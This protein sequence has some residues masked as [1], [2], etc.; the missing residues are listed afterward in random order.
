MDTTNCRK[1][2]EENPNNSANTNI[3]G[4]SETTFSVHTIVYE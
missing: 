3:Y 4:Y 1:I 2:D